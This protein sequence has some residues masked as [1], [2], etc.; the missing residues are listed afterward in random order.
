MQKFVQIQSPA[1]VGSNKL[2]PAVSLPWP[3]WPQAMMATWMQVGSQGGE[4][5]R[6]FCGTSKLEAMHHWTRNNHGFVRRVVGSFP[7]VIYPPF[8]QHGDWQSTTC[9]WF[10]P[11]YEPPF[12]EDFQLAMFDDTRALGEFTS[13]VKNGSKPHDSH[14]HRRYPSQTMGPVCFWVAASNSRRVVP[15]CSCASEFLPWLSWEF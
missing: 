15:G 12:I 1:S 2:H 9:S 13:P 11:S 3:V 6:P 10:S 4:P 5:H 8:I 14:P 7:E